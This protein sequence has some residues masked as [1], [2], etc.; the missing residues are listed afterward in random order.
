M[1]RFR[2][3]A[4]RVYSGFKK[5]YRRSSTGGVKPLQVAVMAGAYGAFRDK[6]H[7]YIPNTGLPYSD[8]LVSG[9][10]GYYLSKKGGYMKNA[11]VAILAV[12][13]A[14]IGSNVMGGTSSSTAGTAT[15]F[16]GWQ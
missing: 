7:S 14:A 15:S 2:R 10:I 11:G 6:I 12:E 13:A 9:A 16:N 1:A 3:K 5:A 4:R 8:S